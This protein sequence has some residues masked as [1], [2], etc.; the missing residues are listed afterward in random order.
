MGFCKQSKSQW[1]AARNPSRNACITS[2]DIIVISNW[3]KKFRNGLNQFLHV[4]G[5]NSIPE[6]LNDSTGIPQLLRGR[7]SPENLSHWTTQSGVLS[8]N[9]QPHTNVYFC[10]AQTPAKRSVSVS[11]ASL[12]LHGKHLLNQ[13]CELSSF[14]VLGFPYHSYFWQRKNLTL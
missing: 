4:K 14:C 6:Q 8:F 2:T 3:R 5:R 10:P 7:T 1:L 12:H 9:P 13:Q 11:G